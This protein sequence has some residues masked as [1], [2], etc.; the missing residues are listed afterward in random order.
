M[1]YCSD[2]KLSRH[3]SI[4]IS[5]QYE[6]MNLQVNIDFSA[7]TLISTSKHI[8]ACLFKITFLI[9]SNMLEK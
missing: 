9:S 2:M 1:L 5:L 3:T 4:L 6:T 7:L 8:G